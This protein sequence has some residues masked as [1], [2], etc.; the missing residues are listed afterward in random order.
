MISWDTVEWIRDLK[1]PKKS[2]ER[3]KRKTTYKMYTRALARHNCGSSIEETRK[4][5]SIIEV[6]QCYK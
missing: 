6:F 5:D 3:A 4:M 1:I 2:Y